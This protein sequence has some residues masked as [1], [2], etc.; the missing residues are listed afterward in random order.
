MKLKFFALFVVIFAV[1]I[2]A[3]PRFD[4]KEQLKDLKEKLNLSEDQSKE[5]ETILVD[6]TEE[7]KKLR[8]DNTGSREEMFPKMMKIREDAN[9]KIE[10]VLNDDQKKAFKKYLEEREKQRRNGFGPGRNKQQ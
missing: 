6:M 8:E 4:P 7:M 9:K 10:N 2:F 1:N 3:Q 5:V